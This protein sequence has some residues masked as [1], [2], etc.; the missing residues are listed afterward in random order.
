MSTNDPIGSGFRSLAD[1]LQ[2]VCVIKFL[3]NFFENVSVFTVSCRQFGP[4]RLLQHF[5]SASGH[6]CN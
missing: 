6:P 5:C 3:V 1:L 2:L 4:G